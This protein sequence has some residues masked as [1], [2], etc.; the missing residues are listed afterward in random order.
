MPKILSSLGFGRENISY[1][2]LYP[3]DSKNLDINL[4]AVFSPFVP[5]NLAKDKLFTIF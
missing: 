3:F 2:T 5:G 4:P 1:D